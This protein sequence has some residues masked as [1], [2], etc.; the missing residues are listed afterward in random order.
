MKKFYL[1]LTIIILFCNS[2]YSQWAPIGAKWTYTMTF[3][4]SNNIDTFVIRSVGDTSIQG[5]LCKILQKNAGLCDLRPLR[6]YMYEDNGKVFFYDNSRNIFQMLYDFNGNIGDSTVIYP[7]DYPSNDYISTIIDSI[8]TINI[9]SHI[10]KKLYLHCS[11][12]SINWIPSNSGVVIE[13]IGDTYYMF[14]WLFGGCDAQWAG[15]LRC[16][17]DTVIGTYNFNTAVS[18]DY[19]FVEINPTKCFINLSTFPNPFTNSTVISIPEYL[20]LNNVT[21]DIF[22][23]QGRE[24]KEFHN[25]NTHQLTLYRTDFNTPGIYFIRIKSAQFSETIKLIVQ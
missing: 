13:N 21:I 20:I 22:D 2:I 12:S 11:P 17:E 16:Y 25:I 8:S 15:P 24:I 18:C 3:N 14:P 10:L 4:M 9:N 5:H 7:D 1:I 23:L 19:V 6:E